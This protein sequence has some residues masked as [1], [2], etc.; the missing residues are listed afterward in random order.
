[1]SS[2]EQKQS[3]DEATLIVSLSALGETQ[4]VTGLERNFVYQYMF[5]V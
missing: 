1:M 5:F 4:L 3:G 2:P